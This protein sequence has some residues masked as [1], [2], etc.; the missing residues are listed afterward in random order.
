MTAMGLIFL[1]QY[2]VPVALILCLLWRF[3]LTPFFSKQIEKDVADAA[4]Q[5]IRE[6]LAEAEEAKVTAPK[7]PSEDE[8]DLAIK[9]LNEND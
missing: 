1:L 2:V 3:V 9:E 5:R 8:I 4:S 6:K 7:L